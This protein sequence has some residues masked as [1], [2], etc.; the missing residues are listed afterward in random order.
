MALKD[1]LAHID[2]DGEKG[3]AATAPPATPDGQAAPPARA[4]AA[5]GAKPLRGTDGTLARYMAESLA[6]SFAVTWRPLPFD[7][8]TFRYGVLWHAR[9]HNDPAHQWFRNQVFAVC[10]QSHFMAGGDRSYPRLVASVS[11]VAN[12]ASVARSA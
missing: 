2:Q 7:P 12:V 8:H 4:K 11:N 9:S 10:Q 3:A 5:P 6:D 1:V